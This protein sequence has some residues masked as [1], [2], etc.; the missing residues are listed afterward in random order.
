MTN[1]ISAG[2]R[3]VLKTISGGILAISGCSSNTDSTDEPTSNST[4]APTTAEPITAEP[5]PSVEEAV[6]ILSHE[7]TLSGTDLTVDVLI[8]NISDIERIT[9]TTTCRI[10]RDDFRVAQADTITSDLQSGI[11]T[12]AEIS[13]Y[14]L[15]FADL[16][17][18]SKYELEV[19]YNRSGDSYI[20]EYEMPDLDVP[21][22]TTNPE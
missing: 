20:R 9:V 19:S 8:E 17:G 4:P 7:V 13:F 15:V 2:R 5:L 10:Y 21:E 3:S 16:R 1:Q 6:E 18:L 11:Q 12:E 22:E 14:G